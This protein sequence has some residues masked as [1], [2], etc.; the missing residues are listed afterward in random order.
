MTVEVIMMGV[1]SISVSWSAAGDTVVDSEVAWRAASGPAGDRD[2]SVSITSTSYTIRGHCD[3]Y[4]SAGY[5]DSLFHDE[6]QKEVKNT[7]LLLLGH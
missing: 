2:S 7:L 1:S 6:T 3:C 5:G 4:S